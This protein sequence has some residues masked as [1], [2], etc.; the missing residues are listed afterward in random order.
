[1]K[2]LKADHLRR[3]EPETMIVSQIEVMEQ[4]KLFM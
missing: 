3:N 1:M 2:H 4:Y